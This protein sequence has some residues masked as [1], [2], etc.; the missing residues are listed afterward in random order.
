MLKTLGA[1]IV[2][3]LLSIRLALAAVDINTATAE[4]LDRLKGIG[5][6][7]AKAIVDYRSKNGSFKSIDDIKKVPGIS[8]ATFQTI[9]SDITVGAPRAKKSGEAKKASDATKKDAPSEKVR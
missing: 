1:V 9:K 5:P 8:D 3:L 2:V 4:D 7:K 6:V